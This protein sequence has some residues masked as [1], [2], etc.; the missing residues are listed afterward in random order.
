MNSAVVS[1]T[2]HDVPAAPTGLTT[3]A[4]AVNASDDTQNDIPL[5]WNSV[6]DA[7]NGGLAITGYN[8]EFLLD[9]P[10]TT[11]ADATGGTPVAHAAGMIE[12]THAGL[13]ENA[14]TPETYYYRVRAVSAAGNGDWSSVTPGVKLDVPGAPT[15][16]T[17]TAVDQQESID[18]FWKMPDE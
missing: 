4:V 6:P 7:N 14:T 18:L 9:P 11:W 8:V 1:G 13:A 16:L 5:S 2:T 3:G 15:E 12:T 17:A 10:G